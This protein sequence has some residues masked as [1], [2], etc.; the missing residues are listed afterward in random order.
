MPPYVP[1]LHAATGIWGKEE[2]QSRKPGGRGG[3]N[4]E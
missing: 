3:E 2:N 4:E 1:A